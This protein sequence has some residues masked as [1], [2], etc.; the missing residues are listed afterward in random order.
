M[1]GL[2]NDLKFRLQRSACS[3][4]FYDRLKCIGESSFLER[5]RSKRVHRSARFTQT[6]AGQLT[7]PTDVTNSMLGVFLQECFFS[8]LHLNNHAGEPLSEGIMNDSRHAGWL[9]ENGCLTLLLDE[10]LSVGSHHNVM[11]QRLSKFD[12]IGSIDALFRMMNTD[13]P[14]KLAGDEHR[15]RHESL[16]LVAV[17]V[18]AEF[19]LEA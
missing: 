9:F 2:A 18:L 8:S 10:L 5:L 6:V 3:R 13:K 15:Y 4:V 17:Q 16:A 19:R 7:R 12:F 11:S 14:T 1:V